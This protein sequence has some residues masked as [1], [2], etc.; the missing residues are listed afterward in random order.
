MRCHVPLKTVTSSYENLKHT[1]EKRDMMQSFEKSKWP[2]DVFERLT[3][4]VSIHSNILVNPALVLAVPEVI[5]EM[6]LTLTTQSILKWRHSRRHSVYT[7]GLHSSLSQYWRQI[8]HRLPLDYNWLKK[9]MFPF[10]LN[11]PNITKLQTTQTI[12]RVNVLNKVVQKI[13]P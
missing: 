5:S 12:W 7:I 4:A 2:F 3:K 9:S 13:Y 1:K 10:T 11:T 6:T 8:T